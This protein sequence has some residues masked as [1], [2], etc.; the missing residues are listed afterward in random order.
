MKSEEGRGRRMIGWVPLAWALVL[1]ALFG[2]SRLS[3]PLYFFPQGQA[4]FVAGDLL[5]NLSGAVAAAAAVL[6]WVLLLRGWGAFAGGWFARGLRRSPLA[7][8]FG[9]GIGFGLLGLAVLGLGLA[10]LLFRPL[11]AALCVLP[12]LGWRLV[13]VLPFPLLPPLRLPGGAT[14]ADRAWWALLAVPVLVALPLMTA[15]EGSW[16]AMVYHLRFPSFFLMEHR[17]FPVMD[18]PFVGYPSLAE[19]HYL[20]ALALPLGGRIPKLI[21]AACWLM[22]ARLLFVAVLPRGRTAARGTALAWLLA[23]LGMHLAGIA[24]V[25]LATAWLS[26]LA[27]AA[28][29]EGAK[30]RDSVVL[31]GAFAGFAFL[32]KLTGGLATAG[33]MAVLGGRGRRVA[34]ALAAAAVVA[35][36]WPA[37]NWLVLGNPLFPF[38]PR[39]LGGLDLPIRGYWPGLESAGWLSRLWSACVSDEAGVGA[40]LGPLWAVFIAAGFVAG[41]G[42][43]WRYFAA[44]LAGWLLLPLDSRFLLPAVPAALLASA[45]AWGD[46][47]TRIALVA[48][49]VLCGPVAVREAARAS[50]VQYSTLYPFLGLRARA[51]YLRL[52]LSPEPEYRD[53]SLRANAELPA[54]ARLFFVAGLKSWYFERRCAIAH[55]HIDPIPLLRM[56][57]EAGSAERLAGRLR[58]GGFTHLVYMPRA[59]LAYPCPGA[60]EMTDAEAGE[61][62]RWFS[63]HTA[64]LF[65]TGEALFYSLLP[66]RR[67]RTPGRVPLLEDGALKAL[68]DPSGQWSAKR[69][70]AQLSRLAPSSSS[71]AMLKGSGLLLGPDRSASRALSFLGRAVRD[72]EVSSVAWRACGYSLFLQGEEDRALACFRQAAD[73]NPADG[74]AHFNAG[75]VFVR[76]GRWDQA[77]EAFGMAY[78]SEP[79]NDAYRRAYYEAAAAVAGAAVPATKLPASGR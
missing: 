50:F 52:G 69:A 62:Y 26:A 30:G 37:R 20:L 21:H 1:A 78:R 24:Y 19:L 74:E 29:R 36:A 2:A 7:A 6:V 43:E 16:D 34:A 5:A 61:Y 45:P 40:V 3:L 42:R 23:P 73:L 9:T 56:L 46:R 38:L 39:V 41:A 13:P 79:S 63:G 25:D 67:A 70:M 66:A 76:R 17:H 33:V 12:F 35:A 58:Q 53:A 44:F 28:A 65:R 64:Y 15:P 77:V 27:V 11:L 10:G 49:L 32:T 14:R 51:E 4:P 47:R 59:A 72:P 22:T 71:V 75:Q 54:R 60:P 31:A 8:H 57:R 48:G 18:S 68:S 55:Q